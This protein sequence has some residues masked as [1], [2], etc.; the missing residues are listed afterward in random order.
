MSSGLLAQARRYGDQLRFSENSRRNGAASFMDTRRKKT[1]AA[2][3]LALIIGAIVGGV[4]GGILGSRDKSTSSDTKDMSISV[5]S[6]D[7]PASVF[8]TVES[9]IA[10]SSTTSSI[11]ASTSTSPCIEGTVADGESQNYLGLC[12]FTCAYG[13]CPPGPCKCTSHGL[14]GAPPPPETGIKGCPLPGESE[15]LYHRLLGLNKDLLV[16]SNPYIILQTIYLF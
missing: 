8:T 16:F 12:K 4:V 7:I 2:S 10:Q 14:D 5:S 6:T 9:S 11:L 15:G 13:Y 3:A 1:L